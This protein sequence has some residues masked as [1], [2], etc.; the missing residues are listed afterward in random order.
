[1]GAAPFAT[2]NGYC[3]FTTRNGCCPIGN[4]HFPVGRC[5]CEALC[6]VY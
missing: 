1:M 6:S 4:T 5:E 3:P 2:R